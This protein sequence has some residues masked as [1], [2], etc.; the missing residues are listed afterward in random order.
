MEFPFPPLPPEYFRLMAARWLCLG[1]NLL[2]LYWLVGRV[3][4]R[5]EV[6]ATDAVWWYGVAVV[7]LVLVGYGTSYRWRIG[8]DWLLPLGAASLSVAIAG[9][10]LSFIKVYE[11][12]RWGPF[13][14]IPLVY[15][16]SLAWLFMPTLGHPREASSRTQCKNQLKQFGLALQNYHD[17]YSVLPAPTPGKPPVS[18]RVAIL[19]YM[20]QSQLHATYNRHVAWDQI[21]N[22]AIARMEIGPYR[23]PSNELPQDAQGRWFT[24]YSMPTGP[25]TV[26][27]NPKGTA[28]RD[29]ADGTSNTLLVVEACGAQ[30]VWT[31][32]RDVDV[33]V[34]PTGINLKGN[35]PGHSAGW[36]SSYHAGGTQ[37]LLADGSVRFVSAKSDPAVL[38]KLATVDGG[39]LV[40]EY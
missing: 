12:Q 1:W 39:E 15:G 14:A 2:A 37:A 35:A 26:G 20:D 4:R 31:E 36:L 18:W 40:G 11:E 13:V 16:L 23:C 27:A 9:A 5:K 19:P 7:G 17:T 38:K 25:K 34:Q 29:I 21:P 33:S 3:R 6:R 28:I 10:T 24:A 8:N 30:I 22:D 32:P